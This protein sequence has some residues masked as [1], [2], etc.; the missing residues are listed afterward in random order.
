MTELERIFGSIRRHGWKIAAA[1]LVGFVLS[2][3]AVQSIKDRYTA[4]TLLIMDQRVSRLLGTE[5]GNAAGSSPD[6]EVE[7]LKSWNIAENVV[8]RL[9]LHTAPDFA[10]R[11]G[12]VS[13]LGAQVGDAWQDVR[14]KLGWPRAETPDVQADEATGPQGTSTGAAVRM[15]QQRITVRRRGL[16]DVI[17]IEA[18][19]DNP[20]RAAQLANAYADAYIEEHVTAKVRSIE[21]AEETLS[22]R[23]AELS[24]ALKK[25]ETQLTM[26]QL[27][28]DTLAR[29]KTVSQ[30]RTVVTADA[31][32]AAEARPPDRPSFPP[33]EI[34]TLLGGFLA[35]LMS[36]VLAYGRDHYSRIIRTE[37][38]IEAI[39]GVRNIGVL[40]AGQ[41]RRR[42]H[43]EIVNNPFSAFSEAIRRT[44]LGLEL[45]TT[46]GERKKTVLL[47][48]TA[49]GDGKTTV[50]IA[51]SRA[52]AGSGLRTVIIDCDLLRPKL[53]ERLGIDKGPG[54]AD[55]MAAEGKQ[56]LDA[57]LKP[58]PRSNC[59]VVTAGEGSRVTSARLFQSPEFAAFLSELERRF[60]FV[61]LDAP[62]VGPM[63]GIL[64]LMRSVD[65]VLFVARG[66]AT[67]A[68]DA[69]LA[70]REVFR[71]HPA[72]VLTMLNQSERWVGYGY[73]YK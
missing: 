72:N 2:Y 14:A 1:T 11:P 71:A 33:R 28:Q 41:S 52:A 59:T 37:A 49:S 30:Q 26:R 36:T 64:L 39:S 56:D 27:Y 57:L 3:L 38:D 65:T 60:D 62:P 34:L 17:A 66:G 54:L 47:T 13:R 73:S 68:H 20:D 23:L 18:T 67:K 53:H 25:S 50:S 69:R 24:E 61:V 12:L 6:S 5:G 44:F 43:D 10:E 22:R 45:M 51:L 29:M 19:A 16:T 9:D 8:E 58:D 55:L 42:L 46:S 4:T 32:V 40:P 15:L 31:R 48:S 21:R 70:L 63:A 7:I 35:F